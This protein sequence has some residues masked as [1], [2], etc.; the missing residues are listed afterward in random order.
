MKKQYHHWVEDD[1]YDKWIQKEPR[2]FS[3]DFGAILAILFGM[4]TILLIV[5]GILIWL[6][7]K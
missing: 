7:F 5:F 2:G 3:I 4:F 1:P 6:L